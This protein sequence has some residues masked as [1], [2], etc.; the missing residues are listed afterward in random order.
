MIEMFGY[1][2]LRPWWLAMIAA[3]VV[4]GAVA[5]RAS[6][7]LGAWERA[8]DPE[9]LAWMRRSGRV[10]GGGAVRNILPALVIAVLALALA[11]PATE[12][13]AA[14]SYRNLD[15]VVIVLDLSPSVTGSGRLFD[16]ITAARLVAQASGTRQAALVVYAGE[17]YLAQPFSS[18]A[19]ALS[20]TLALVDG[21]TMPVVGSRPAAGLARAHAALEGAEIMAADVVLLSDGAAVGPEAMEQARALA[22]RGWPVSAIAIPGAPEGPGALDALT[23]AGG[24][25]LATL[26]DPFPVAA[27]VSSRP[28]RRLAETGFAMLV[29][30]DHGRYLL[31]LALIPAFLMLP[32][33]R[34]A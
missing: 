28:V 7:R 29:L 23:R 26:E 13:R 27:R 31:L 5:V 20:G 12:R 34:Q 17:A 21:E 25:V 11:G 1:L 30:S 10:S 9:L 3:A 15:G 24:G 22:A 2:W 8:V 16:T 32:R 4:I 33:G 6:G 19:R 14:E 18:D